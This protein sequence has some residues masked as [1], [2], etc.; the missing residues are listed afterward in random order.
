MNAT[1][2][3]H[4]KFCVLAPEAKKAKCDSTQASCTPVEEMNEEDLE[5]EKFAKNLE[6]IQSRP[7]IFLGQRRRKKLKPNFSKDWVKSLRKQLKSQLTDGPI[8]SSESMSS[9]TSDR[10]GNQS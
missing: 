8:S 1:K 5:I 9:Y 4:E 3:V 6:Q 10:N 2:F 7:P